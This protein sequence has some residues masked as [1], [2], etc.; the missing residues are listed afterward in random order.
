MTDYVDYKKVRVSKKLIK[1]MGEIGPEIKAIADQYN[2]STIQIRTVE[3]GTKSATLH[4]S[5]GQRSWVFY[6]GQVKKITTVSEHTVGFP[7]LNQDICGQAAMPAGATFVEVSYL[8]Q[9]YMYVTS[10][11][12]PVVALPMG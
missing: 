4:N 10:V 12:E 7:G 1:E 6:Q 3:A 11:V 5:E 8:G 9:Y 2:V